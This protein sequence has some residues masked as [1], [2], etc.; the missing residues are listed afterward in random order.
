MGM[1]RLPNNG[2][3]AYYRCSRRRRT[4][5]RRRSPI[6]QL[7]KSAAALNG[8]IEGW[9]GLL[10][11]GG[12]VVPCHDAR[13]YLL[14]RPIDLD[15]IKK[16]AAQNGSFN[17][18][19]A[20]MYI[21]YVMVNPDTQAKS[22]YAQ[23]RTDAK[24]RFEFRGLPGDRWY[25]VMAQALGSMMVSWQTAVYLYPKERVQVVLTNTNASLP[26]YTEEVS[27]EVDGLGPAAGREGRTRGK[28][29]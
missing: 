15:S 21:E 9:I 14:V 3:G 16:K 29:F 24:G 28:L 18:R 17:L 25:Y 12:R 23:M 19:L 2:R 10:Q 13:V 8:T 11:S 6:T 26:I 1:R 27:I 5:F 7:A 22:A 20:H 4:I